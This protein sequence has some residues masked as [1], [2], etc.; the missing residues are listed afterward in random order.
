MVA[1]ITNCFSEYNNKKHRTNNMKPINITKKNEQK[2]LKTVYNRIKIVSN[3][4][5]K[6]QINDNV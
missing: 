1:I 3:K 4:K 2:L 5:P 6:F